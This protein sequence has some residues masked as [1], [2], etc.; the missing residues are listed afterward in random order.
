MWA[1]FLWAMKVYSLASDAYKIISEMAQRLPAKERKRLLLDLEFSK[2]APANEIG[3]IIAFTIAGYQR[4]HTIGSRLYDVE[5]NVLDEDGSQLDLILHADANG[6]LMELEI[7]RYAEGSV[8]KPD[9]TTLSLYL[10][11][12]R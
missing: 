6:R 9:W 5:A 3:T 2:A 8:I 10:R 12:L 7:V 4:P 1:R 11:S